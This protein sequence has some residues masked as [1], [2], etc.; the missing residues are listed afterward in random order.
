MVLA[1]DTLLV[2][3]PP[4]VVDE[5]AMWGRSNA[6]EF[7]AKMREQSEALEGAKGSVLRAVSKKDG[8]TLSETKHEWLPAF[9][10]MIAAGGR[11]YVSV[12]GGEVVCLE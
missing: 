1:N 5:K 8:K 6:P 11:V 12:A 10:G 3:G 2:A 9:D 4:D 7:A